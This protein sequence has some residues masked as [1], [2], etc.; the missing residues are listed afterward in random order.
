VRNK[1]SVGI[2]KTSLTQH[3]QK[4]GSSGQVMSWEDVDILLVNAEVQGRAGLRNIMMQ[5]GYRGVRDVA[6]VSDAR[7]RIQ[8]SPP[9]LL[10]VDSSMPDG[11]SIAMIEDIRFKR[12]GYNPFLV[13]MVMIW[14]PSRETVDRI[15]KCGVDD[16]LA[17]PHAPMKV[18]ERMNYFAGNRHQFI[19]TSEYIGPHRGDRKK[20][21]GAEIDLADDLLR[22]DVPNTLGAKA[23]GEQIDF[24]E[25]QEMVSSAMHEINDQRLRSHSLRIAAIVDKVVPAY[26]KNIATLAIQQEV[27]RLSNISK[28]ISERL[29]DSDFEHVTDLCETLDYVT[30]SIR[31][32]LRNPDPRDVD[33]LKAVSDAIVVSFNPEKASAEFA[34]EV[35][36]MVSD[37]YHK[38]QEE[39]AASKEQQQPAD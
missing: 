12:L 25:L 19:V 37:K 11:D 26:Q 6:T 16:L 3:L 34:A 35:T 24:V 23:A 28:E 38:R 29:V 21:E 39:Q 20:N 31:S 18:M 13:I 8:M 7:A 33:L 15:L 4:P 5:Q 14:S 2:K 9:D 36:Q 30:T 22:I 10:V 1:S 17:R 32:D 27:V